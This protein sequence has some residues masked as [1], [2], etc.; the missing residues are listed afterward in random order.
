MYFFNC[1]ILEYIISTFEPIQTFY[2]AIF[3]ILIFTS[4]HFYIFIFFFLFLHHIFNFLHVFHLFFLNVASFYLMFSCFYTFF[5]SI[6]H[7]LIFMSFSFIYFSF[8]FFSEFN[9][10]SRVENKIQKFEKSL[11]VL[12]T[13]Q[14]ANKKVGKKKKNENYR[15]VYENTRKIK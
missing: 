4:L 8:S 9:E 2:L 5:P 11:M 13:E 6:C 7:I 12:N 3:K 14:K 10:H 1:Y 15:F